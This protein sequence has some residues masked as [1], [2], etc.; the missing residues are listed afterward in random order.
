MQLTRKKAL[1]L[2]REGSSTQEIL[3]LAQGTIG[4]SAKAHHLIA[5][6]PA[7]RAL[8]HERFIH[9]FVCGMWT[10]LSLF[11]SMGV[12]FAP[13]IEEGVACLLTFGFTWAIVTWNGH[14]LK[15]GVVWLLVAMVVSAN[16]VSAADLEDPVLAWF[17]IVSGVLLL[18][19]IGGMLYLRMRLFPRMGWWGSGPLQ[20]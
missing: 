6:L 12:V 11:M 5:S 8:R 16:E 9:W 17:L 1:A 7:R 3:E 15:W 4:D 14:A 19:A 18:I 13:G 20:F 2:I 10:L